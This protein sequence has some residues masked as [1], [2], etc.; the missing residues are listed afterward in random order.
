MTQVVLLGRYGAAAPSPGE[1]SYPTIVG[2]ATSAEL[3]ATTTHTVSLPAGIQE[4][5]LLVVFVATAS[6]GS[7]EVVGPSG[8]TELYSTT[9]GTSGEACCWYKEATGAEGTTVTFT[10]T[11]FGRRSAHNAYRIAGWDATQVPQAGTVATGTS[12][13]PNPPS[14]T[15]SWGSAKGLWLAAMHGAHGNAVTAFPA[16][17][18]TALNA[19]TNV[20]NE[21]HAR[22][23]TARREYEGATQ[24][25]AAFTLVGSSAWAANT[26]AVKGATGDVTV[27]A[28]VGAVTVQGYSAT[29]T[30]GSITYDSLDV[31]VAAVRDS[32][33]N[34]PAVSYWGEYDPLYFIGNSSGMT[35]ALRFTGLGIPQGATIINAYLTVYVADGFDQG[36]DSTAWVTVGAEQV[37]NASQLTSASNHESRKTN[38]GT[39]VQWGPHGGLAQRAAFVSPN[40][41][42]VVQEIVDR[43]GW[44]SGNAM[45]FFMT[46]NPSTTSD[47]QFMSYWSGNA[48]YYPRLEI[49]WSVP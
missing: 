21:W 4:G 41:A 23:V 29:V 19:W 30:A 49:S 3:E 11:D 24:D 40:L 34:V 17:Y 46:P 5:E 42:T 44:S 2:T 26:V 36:V 39:T 7:G 9:V 22:M 37:D 47:F 20:S 38:L 13:G 18:G 33:S 45:Q 48:A 31:R 6:A 27:T 8:W 25:P 1:E 14:L 28:P 12:T 16:N 15:V 35:T 32:I 43:S 10:M